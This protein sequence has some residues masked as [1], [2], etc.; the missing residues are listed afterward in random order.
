MDLI[1][2]D[3]NGND[4]GVLLSYALDISYG[5][6]DNNFELSVSASTPNIQ[7]N[8]FIYFENT[9]YGGIVDAIKSSTRSDVVKY[10][11]RTWHGILNSKVLE[12]DSGE[13]YLIVNG[14]ANNVLRSLVARVGLSDLFDV[15]SNKSEISISKYQFAR[16]C[17]AY[18]GIATMLSSNGAKLIMSFFGKKIKLSAKA[19]EDYSESGTDLNDAILSVDKTYGKINHLICLGA[20]ELADRNVLHLYADDEGNIGHTQYY[21]GLQE[22]CEIYENTVTEELESDAITRFKLLRN[23]DSADA[24]IPETQDLHFEIGDIV[25]AVEYKTGVKISERIT[26]KIVSAKN[27]TISVEYKIGG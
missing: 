2:T 9:E 22:I 20:G 19:I 7:P 5:R 16:Y 17:K 18:D 13:D 8:S 23:I 3:A 12:P 25:S 10:S 1:Y 27:G 6:E 21:T 24:S 15:D 11:G 26:Q 4:V 14:D